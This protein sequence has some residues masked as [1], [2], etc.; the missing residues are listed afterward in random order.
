M[1]LP[2]NMK[3]G[4]DWQS[5]EGLVL[6]DGNWSCPRCGQTSGDDWSQ[7]EGVCPV[8]MSPHYDPKAPLYP[9]SDWKYEV[10]NN[11]T[12]LGYTEWLAQKMEIPF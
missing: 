5:A 8:K 4:S 12:Q 3:L 11:D 2:E 10:A 9:V 7:C 6:V 1:S